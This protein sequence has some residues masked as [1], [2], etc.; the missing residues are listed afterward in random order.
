MRPGVSVDDAQAALEGFAARQRATY[1]EEA[2]DELEL[3][4][5]PLQGEVV[6]YAKGPLVLLLSAVG[7]V[8]LIACANV[9]T[10]FLAR[11][12][13]RTEELALRRALGARTRDVMGAA[14]GESFLAAGLGATV[15]IVAAPFLA[16]T[17]LALAP[18]IFHGPGGRR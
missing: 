5:A 6:A 4:A 16:G 7:F 1:Q 15:G 8:L 10:L 14:L 17:M 3:R 18:G 13:D 9:A 2:T 11:G 12:G